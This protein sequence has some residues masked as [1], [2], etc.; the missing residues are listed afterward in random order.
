MATARMG[1]TI[2][3]VHTISFGRSI[4]QAIAAAAVAAIRPMTHSPL[5]VSR[6]LVP[7]PLR[8]PHVPPLPAFAAF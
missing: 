1:Q 6:I 4:I 8:T 2:R 3:T 7:A 5:I